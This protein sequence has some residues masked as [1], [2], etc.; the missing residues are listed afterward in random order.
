MF[1]SDQKNSSSSPAFVI[2]YKG[3]ILFIEM[4][5]LLLPENAVI[6]SLNYS[7]RWSC[8]DGVGDSGVNC[9]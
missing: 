2:R 8:T 9:V 7:I 5:S 3:K 4:R 6:T 1:T